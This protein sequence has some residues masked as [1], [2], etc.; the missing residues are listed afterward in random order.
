MNNYV[1]VVWLA[2]NILILKGDILCQ[3]NAIAAN[4]AHVNVKAA[5]K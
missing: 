3:V 2:Y 4:A 1:H 5:A